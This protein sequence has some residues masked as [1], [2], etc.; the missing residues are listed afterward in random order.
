MKKIVNLKKALVVL[1][2]IAISFAAF[3]AINNVRAWSCGVI[4][5]PLSSKTVEENGQIKFTLTYVD[6]V[7]R[8]T[9][10]ASDLYLNGF[11]A[12]IHI[13]DAG[14]SRVVTL[15]N[16]HNTSGSSLKRVRISGGT[17]VSSDGQ[18]AHSTQTE[19]FTIKASQGQEENKDTVA[20]VA[21]ISGPNPSQVY[22]GGTVTY[23][24]TYSE[25]VKVQ[26]ITL[27]EGDI[28][29]DGFSAN[30]SVSI[31]GNTATITLSNIK[32]NVGGN[33]TIYVSGGTAYD[34]QGNLCN[35]VTGS[36][37]TLLSKDT[38]S[39][40]NNPSDNP[41]KDTNKNNK[42]T[43]KNNNSSKPSD[44]VANPNTGK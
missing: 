27:N 30:K 17:A 12:N 34:A 25:N 37:F 44:W 40:P 7:N 33:K 8:I 38:P 9:L 41:N 29:L 31:S 21:K 43:N 6:D 35:G 13:A 22:I 23:K 2:I 39:N 26:G 28:R 3:P 10:N 20:P 36:A 16:I 19:S 1:S 11:T 24:V 42:D 18:L 15:S 14:N 5:T 32:G 4:V